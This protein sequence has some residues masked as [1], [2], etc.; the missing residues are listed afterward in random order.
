M[1]NPLAAWAKRA[2]TMDT[3]WPKA[4]IA[5]AKK[6]AERLKGSVAKDKVDNPFAL[7]RF[8]TAHKSKGG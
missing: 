3:K 2:K 8:I 6:L 4:E 5:K 7:A 1:S